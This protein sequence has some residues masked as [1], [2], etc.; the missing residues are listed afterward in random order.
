L[1]QRDTMTA[2]VSAWQWHGSA[3]THCWPWRG[4]RRP[5]GRIDC[6]SRCQAGGGQSRRANDCT[7]RR[8]HY[9]NGGASNGARQRRPRDAAAR[10]VSGEHG[11]HSCMGHVTLA[12]I[13]SGGSDCR[14]LPGRAPTA[15]HSPAGSIGMHASTLQIAARCGFH[16]NN[17][18][19]FVAEIMQY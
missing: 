8:G 7:G 12:R 13:G 19:Q 18:A 4:H 9:W 3:G 1:E 2:G 17:E 11:W 6:W 10:G 15:N 14:R 16:L 5:D